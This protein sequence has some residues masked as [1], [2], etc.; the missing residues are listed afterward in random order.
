MVNNMY[1]FNVIDHERKR[2]NEREFVLC[3]SIASETDNLNYIRLIT[4]QGFVLS[5]RQEVGLI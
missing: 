1:M 3:L 2:Q 5:G 4:Y